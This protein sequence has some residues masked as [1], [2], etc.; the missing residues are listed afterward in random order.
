[1]LLLMKDV[2]YTSALFLIVWQFLCQKYFGLAL[3]RDIK[4]CET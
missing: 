1:M 4:R 2:K 3:D